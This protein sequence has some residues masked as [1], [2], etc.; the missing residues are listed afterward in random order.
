MEGHKRNSPTSV[1]LA[2]RLNPKIWFSATTDYE[3]TKVLHMGL[4]GKVVKARCKYSNRMV[5][6]KYIS[7]CL[8]TEYICVRA[9]R[10]IKIMRELTQM[11]S[12]FSPELIDAFL[13]NC[14]TS[15]QYFGFFL[16]M[17]FFENSLNTLMNR[18][19]LFKQKDLEVLVY[20]L[21]CALKYLHSANILHR[22]I[23]PSN[24]LID[25]N[26]N[27]KICDYGISRT[28]P[29][30]CIG[31]GSGNTKRMRD[32]IMRQKVMS[33]TDEDDV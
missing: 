16:V 33:T 10:E 8:Q 4:C 6:I 1:L 19:D 14:E 31:K 13:V 20:N 15:S 22:D 7:K 26:C 32:F 23:K 11:G 5:A 30:S 9:I 2:L 12:T 18:I 25:A 28:Q 27:V 21:L 24:I 29:L 3:L 17:E